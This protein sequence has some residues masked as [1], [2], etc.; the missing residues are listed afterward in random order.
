MSDNIIEQKAQ[1]AGFSVR[2]IILISMI[3]GVVCFI[4][5]LLWAK[6]LSRSTQIDRPSAL[7]SLQNAKFVVV[8][9]PVVLREIAAQGNNDLSLLANL[10]HALQQ[11]AKECACTVLTKGAVLASAD[12]LP[13]YT[14]QILNG[15]T[16]RKNAAQAPS[17]A[18]QSSLLK[19]LGE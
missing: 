7:P 14:Q 17:P 4:G 3:I 19:M 8:D 16:A 10:D 5:S 15:V 11:L 2:I 18:P 9:I 6:N 13:D 12:S 1:E